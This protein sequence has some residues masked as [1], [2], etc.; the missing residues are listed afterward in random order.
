MTGTVR[1]QER[2]SV[3]W[4]GWGKGARGRSGMNAAEGGRAASRGGCGQRGPGSSRN[5]HT[6]QE[7]VCSF[8]GELM[9]HNL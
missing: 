5:S 3:P 7:S 9:T 4:K 2:G 8:R 6:S 1:E